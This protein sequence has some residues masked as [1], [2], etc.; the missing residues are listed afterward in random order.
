MDD[1]RRDEA[2]DAADRRGLHSA[3]ADDVEKLVAL[4]PDDRERHALRRRSELQVAPAAELQPD[5]RELCTP[6]AGR[7]AERS[8]AAPAVAEQLALPQPEPLAERSPKPR[9]PLA[10]KKMVLRAVAQD[11]PEEQLLAKTRQARM[12]LE[13]QPRVAR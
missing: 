7:F 9:A 12:E 2:A 4:A 13:A 11:A 1:A 10:Q 6:A 3:Q 8:C 5:A